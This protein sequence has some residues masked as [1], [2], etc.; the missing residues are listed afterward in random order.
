[1]PSLPT[2]WAGHLIT[3]SISRRIPSNALSFLVAG[4]NAEDEEYP[5]LT[6]FF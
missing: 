2:H 5:A 6:G 4:K 1:V 3:R